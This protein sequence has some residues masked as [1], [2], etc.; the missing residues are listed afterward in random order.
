MNGP[1]E[2]S[3]QVK[4]FLRALLKQCSWRNRTG[5]QQLQVWLGTSC[6]CWEQ[7]LIHHF[8]FKGSLTTK[9]QTACKVALCQEIDWK[10][11]IRIVIKWLSE[12]QLNIPSCWLRCQDS[13]PFHFLLDLLCSALD[14]H[15]W[16]ARSQR[17]A[18]APARRDLGYECAYL[19]GKDQ[20]WQAWQEARICPSICA[21]GWYVTVDEEELLPGLN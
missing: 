15:W 2:R 5:S 4:N 3:F 1:A 9:A 16:F 20:S 12:K 14:G 19:T 6:S 7:S 13:L 11:Q 8:A 21:W 17:A 10:W 18:L